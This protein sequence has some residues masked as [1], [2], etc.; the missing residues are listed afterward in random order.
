MA[1]RDVDV[2]EMTA[3]EQLAVASGS[4]AYAG[5]CDE[6]DMTPSL[7]DFYQ[8]GVD[9]IEADRIA[10]EMFGQPSERGR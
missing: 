4:R 5:F 9:L 1:E 7:P 6:H 2:Q 3:L 8:E 10:V